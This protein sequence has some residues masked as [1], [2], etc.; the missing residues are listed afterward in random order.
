MTRRG[1][2][3]FGGSFDP[4]HCGHLLVAERLQALED[5]ECVTFV[6]ARRSPHKRRTYAAAVH[7]LAM[8]RLALHG[9]PGFRLSEF[10]LR[11]TT[12]SYTIDTVRELGGGGE[13]PVLLLGGDALLD[14]HTWHEAEAL[15]RECRIVVYARPGS[16]AAEGRARELGL[17]YHAGVVSPVAS[18]TVRDLVR[19]GGSIHGLVPDTVRRYIETH[20][21]YAARRRT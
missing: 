16:E 21:L 1:V 14:L 19:R 20:G 3:I 7:R 11:R 10:E 18:R 15:Q 12:P 9:R 13:R 6:P 2:A 8:L 17:A 4:V 5:L